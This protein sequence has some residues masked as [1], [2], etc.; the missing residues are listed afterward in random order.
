VFALPVAPNPNRA[1]FIAYSSCGNENW[2]FNDDGLIASRYASINDIPILGS[3]R[4][5]H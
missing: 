4:K 5:Y 3:E 1:T 2:E